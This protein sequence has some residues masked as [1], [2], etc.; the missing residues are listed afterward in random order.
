MTKRKD[1]P[2]RNRR[3][4]LALGAR[5]AVGAVAAPFIAG[6]RLHAQAPP[7]LPEITS[8]PERLKGSGELRVVA[9]GGTA[10]DAERKAYFEPFERLAG[11]TT[12]DFPGADINK[13]KAM[14]E[15]GNVEWD[16]VQL[17]RATVKSL[18]SHGDYFEKIDYDLVDTESI[19]PLYR[20]EYALD[21]LVWS[22][23]MA[24]RTDAYKGAAPSG[25]QDFWDARKFPGDRTMIGGGANFPELE[26]AVMAAGV[27]AANVYPID[28]D[29][30]FASYD[31]IKP[32]IV[33]FWDTGALPVQMLADREVTLATVWNG[34]MLALEQAGVPAAI[35]WNQGLLKRD[36]WA[37][38]KGAKNRDN[39]MKFIAFS[40]MPIPQARLSTLITY[41][42]VNSKAAEYIPPAQLQR[43]PSAPAIKSQLVAYDYDWWTANRE[44]VM[45][46][47]NK[48]LLE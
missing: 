8:I 20:Y 44:S 37:V 47:W 19:D 24:Y 6:S 29:K 7:A 9:Y 33:K 30:A 39:A 25:W 45:V 31:R 28:L 42:F 17:S 43:L 36:C 1:T 26:F 11:V 3:R 35:S 13:V 38:P 2:D 22:Q 18:Q 16:V 15:T 40:T 27:P 46:R 34:R 14:V 4:L 12:R 5:G 10:Q 21:M 23:V 41:G 32:H 48:W